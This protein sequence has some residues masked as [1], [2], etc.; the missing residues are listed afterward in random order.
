MEVTILGTGT[1]TPMLER[2]ASGIAVR[3]ADLLIVVDMGPGT[4]RRMLEAG[5]DTRLVDVILVT[6]FHPDHVSDI[7]PFLFASNYAFGPVREDPFELIGPDG[8]EQYFS[9]LVAVYNEWI[10]PRGN[11][12]IKREM[13]SRKL[14]SLRIGRVDIYS[15]PSVHTGASLHYRIDADGASVTVSGDTDVSEVLVELAAESDILICEC[16]LPDGQKIPGHLVPSEAGR[17]AARAGVKKLVLT[18]FYPPCEEVDVVAQA[19]KTFSGEIVRAE[20]LMVIRP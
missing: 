4:I 14:D 8:L 20:D 11:R 17:I 16:S 15:A 3:A 13:S 9:G 2:N 12:L 19:A 18:H 6:H 7:A 1:A 10:V 5:I